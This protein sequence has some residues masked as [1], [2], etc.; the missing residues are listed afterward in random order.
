L[1]ITES[2]QNASVC[3]RMN[4]LWFSSCSCSLLRLSN[5]GSQWMQSTSGR[6]PIVV[7]PERGE[8]PQNRLCC[9]QVSDILQSMQSVYLES[10]WM[11]MQKYVLSYSICSWLFFPFLCFLLTG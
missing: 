5:C 4:C 8:R 3:S 9:L 7:V 6:A 2:Q 1:G 11:E 10:N